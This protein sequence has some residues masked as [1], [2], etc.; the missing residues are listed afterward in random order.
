M[1]NTTVRAM[2]SKLPLFPYCQTTDGSKVPKKNFNKIAKTLFRHF[3]LKM[4]TEGADQNRGGKLHRNPDGDGE[5][6]AKRKKRD[7]KAFV[8]ENE[9]EKDRSFTKSI[10]FCV[11]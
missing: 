3:R 1:F 7:Q 4:C 10:Y 2:T 9:T 5:I 6:N 8:S 11:S